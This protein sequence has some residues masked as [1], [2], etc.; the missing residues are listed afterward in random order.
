MGTLDPVRGPLRPASDWA[1]L[2]QALTRT[3][4]VTMPDDISLPCDL[5]KGV[6]SAA[7][8]WAARRA[9]PP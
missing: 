7:I 1:A 8:G 9:I 2:T 4:T 6:G 3:V 5:T